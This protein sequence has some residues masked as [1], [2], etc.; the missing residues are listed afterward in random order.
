MVNKVILVGNLAAD[1]EVKATPAGM[2]V[3]KMRL[4]TNPY[5]GKDGERKSGEEGLHAGGEGGGQGAVAH[6]LDKGG[7]DG[8]GIGAEQRVDVAAEKLP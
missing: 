4:A 7:K 3:A 2:F 8:A 6:H 5:A 1:P